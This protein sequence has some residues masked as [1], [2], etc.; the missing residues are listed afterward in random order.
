MCSSERMLP[1]AD[2]LRICYLAITG[3]THGQEP[4]LVPEPAFCILCQLTLHASANGKSGKVVCFPGR[5]QPPPG[6]L[7]GVGG[8]VKA[9]C[10]AWQSGFC[11]A[12]NAAC[13]RAE[14]RNINSG[15]PDSHKI[16]SARNNEDNRQRPSCHALRLLCGGC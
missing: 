16:S 2:P 3:P 7:N 12:T 4:E 6:S 11:E 13:G 14:K 5:C 10:R 15:T 1:A 8:L 9:G